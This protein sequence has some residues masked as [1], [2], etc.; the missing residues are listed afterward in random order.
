[1]EVDQSIQIKVD[2]KT[3]EGLITT[4]TAS[5]IVVTIT[6]P[7]VTLVDT[8]HIAYFARAHCTFEGEYGDKTANDLLESLYEMGKYLED[9]LKRIKPD[10]DQ[11]MAKAGALETEL[12]AANKERIGLLRQLW[13]EE[14][15]TRSFSTQ[16]SPLRKKRKQLESVIGELHD[17]FE[18]TY[19]GYPL[20]H[21]SDDAD[22]KDILEGKRPLLASDVSCGVTK[23]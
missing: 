4:R 14:I 13:K 3:V 8:C 16:W 12:L 1:M 6:K 5:D 19:F 17:T 20:S 15:S 2:N 7:Y 22:V 23:G 10:Y 11:V 9:N 21:H 18:N